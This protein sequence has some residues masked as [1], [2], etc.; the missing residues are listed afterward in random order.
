ML[1]PLNAAGDLPA[2][3]HLAGW[4]DIASRFGTGSSARVDLLQTL[5]EII[6]LATR[7]GELRRLYIFGS[8]VS[9][10]SEPHDIDV[11]LVMTDRF[12]PQTCPPESR[13]LFFH[14]YAQD[15]YGASIFWLTEGTLT[16]PLLRDFLDAWQTKR[17]G[18][19][20]GIVELAA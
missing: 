18:S 3:I 15:T 16:E 11:V 14:S 17:D 13:D 5:R 10:V 9:A 4:A 12:S 2:G 20:R 6:D 19:K 7:T 1:P 8:F